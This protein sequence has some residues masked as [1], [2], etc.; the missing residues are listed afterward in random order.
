[1]TDADIAD[2]FRGLGPVT[3]RRMFGGK[4]IYHQGVIVALEVDGEVLLKADAESA[5]AFRAAGSRQW[6]YAGKPGRRA[7]AMPYWSIPDAA[8]DDPDAMAQWA[9]RAFAAGLRAR[10]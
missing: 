1:M 8:L 4:G 2:L 5:S 7:A 9:Q 6:V 3:V 10:R